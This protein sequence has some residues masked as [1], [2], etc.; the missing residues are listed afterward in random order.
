[1]K[2][3]PTPLITIEKNIPIP[4]GKGA[5]NGIIP[6]YP[7]HDMKAIGDAFFVP[8]KTVLQFSPNASQFKRLHPE[9]NF[10]CRPA[11]KNGVKGC[12]CWRIKVVKK[13]GKAGKK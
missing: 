4:P 9:F 6:K 10:T 1:M 12:R 2:A 13:A 11:I 8:K 7:F 3:K 5:V